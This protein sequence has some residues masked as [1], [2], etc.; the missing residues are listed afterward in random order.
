M[1]R[2]VIDSAYFFHQCLI[3][4]SIICIFPQQ[5]L[6]PSAHDDI[7][8]TRVCSSVILFLAQ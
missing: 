5:L 7:W 4:I 1:F 2:N 3:V 6:K 8:K